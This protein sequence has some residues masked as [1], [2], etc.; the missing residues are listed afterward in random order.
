MWVKKQLLESVMTQLTGFKLTKE[1]D[2]DLYS[3]PVYLTFMKSIAYKMSGWMKH[4]LHSRL[5]RKI[6]I[7]SDMQMTPPS[8]QKVKRN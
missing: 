4:K 8:W 5:M 7:T 2:K 1:Y 3:H 6:S